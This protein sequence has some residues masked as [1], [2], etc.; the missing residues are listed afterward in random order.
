[1]VRCNVEISSAAGWRLTPHNNHHKTQRRRRK[2]KPT[3]PSPKMLNSHKFEVNEGQTC[4]TWKLQLRGSG[5]NKKQIPPT[6]GPF[7]LACSA[8]LQR[9]NCAWVR[10]GREGDSAALTGW[11]RPARGAGKALRARGAGGGGLCRSERG[12]A[13]QR[14]PRQSPGRKERPSPAGGGG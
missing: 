9:G 2:K 13:G 10:S 4:K 7:V 5:G 8:R 14:R 12:T 1:M 6:M 3:A 11:H